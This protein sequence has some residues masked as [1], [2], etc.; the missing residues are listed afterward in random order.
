MYRARILDGH[1]HAVDTRI[2]VYLHHLIYSISI[3]SRVEGQSFYSTIYGISAYIVKEQ[4]TVIY[5]MK[6]SEM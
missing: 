5:L 2:L 6:G 3:D 1:M 4:A